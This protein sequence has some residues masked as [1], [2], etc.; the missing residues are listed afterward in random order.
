MNEFIKFFNSHVKPN[1]S[2]HLVISY[3]KICD[4]RIHIFIRKGNDDGSDLT[5]FDDNH[6]DAEYLA[7]KAQIA[8][9]DYLSETYGGY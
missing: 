5:I 1:Y 6:C 4:W 9:K 3:C 2:M 7:A 8:L